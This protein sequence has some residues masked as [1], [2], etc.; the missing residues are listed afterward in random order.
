[1]FSLGKEQ[2][3]V[4]AR[5]STQKSSQEWGISNYWAH[6]Q[7]HPP[8]SK[9]LECP[10]SAANL[11]VHFGRHWFLEF[12]NEISC[13]IFKVSLERKRRSGHRGHSLYFRCGILSKAK[14]RGRMSLDPSEGSRLLSLSC[15]PFM[16]LGAS[17]SHSSIFPLLREMML[18]LSQIHGL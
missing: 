8:Q 3:A 17:A 16:L 13:S 9:F 4:S 10:S 7:M 6:W 5:H 15:A 2:E 18:I 14:W 12:S 1:M 11:Q